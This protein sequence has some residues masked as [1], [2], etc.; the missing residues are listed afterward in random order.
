MQDV[1]EI[2][3][4]GVNKYNA[5]RMVQRLYQWGLKSLFI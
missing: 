3:T 2:I 1:T 5:K 4:A